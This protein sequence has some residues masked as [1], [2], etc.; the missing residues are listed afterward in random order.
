MA[1]ATISLVSVQ[2]PSTSS[3]PLLQ[4]RAKFAS[5]IEQQINK[6]ALF[7]EGKRVSKETFWVDSN[8]G[9]FLALRY[10]RQPLELE[11]GKSTLK[12]VGTG[13]AAWDDLVEQL[14]QI[15]TL[16]VAGGLD[17]AL[18]AC[19]NAVRSNFKTAKDKKAGRG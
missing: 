18:S 17:D 1:R 11:K 2:K 19:A 6:I 7:R 3:S 8:G 14:E 16:T 13:N 5:S 12:A 4:R 15:K 10:G 9:I